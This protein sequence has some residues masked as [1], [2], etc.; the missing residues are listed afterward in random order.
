MEPRSELVN[1]NGA[2]LWTA[3]QGR[4][5][6]MV[7]CH[8]GPG[9]YDYLGPIAAMVDDVCLVLR[10]DQRGSGRSEA[11]PPYTVDV[12]VEDLE[13]LR[14]HFGLANWV[15]GGHSWGAGLALAYATRYP[16]HTRALVYL[17]GTGIDPRWHEEY[18][19]NR[20][21][22]LSEAERQEFEDLTRRL[23]ASTDD[24][25]IGMQARRRHLSRRTDV[26]DAASVGDLPT[27][28]EHPTSD[29]VNRLVGAD[30]DAYMQRPAFRKSVCS[31]TMPALLLHGDADPRPAHFAQALAD[32]LTCADFGLIPRAGHYPWIE[33]PT[34]VRAALSRFLAGPA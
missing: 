32:S 10:Y 21:A 9:G 17:S 27:F 31:L 26:F 2:R 16:Q 8:G 3:L 11:I 14:T 34:L 13:S 22:C 24:E 30:W 4:G 18:Q 19:A 25:G 33:Q 28:E 6:P 1:A 15:V 20:L 23:D 12:F 29:E 7:L 5:R